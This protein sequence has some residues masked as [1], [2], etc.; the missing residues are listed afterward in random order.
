MPGRA[1]EVNLYEPRN[2]G[3][4]FSPTLV[5][6]RSTGLQP[7]REHLSIVSETLTEMHLLTQPEN[8]NPSCY[9]NR[10][11]MPRIRWV[12]ILYP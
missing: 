3:R 2:E 9:M 6:L 12:T 10:A 8:R 11:P 1:R 7:S 5:F 4:G